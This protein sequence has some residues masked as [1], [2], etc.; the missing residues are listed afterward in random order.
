MTAIKLKT[1][2]YERIEH[3]TEEQF[4]KLNDIVEKEFNNTIPR[5]DKPKKRQLGTMPDLIKYMSPDFD[6]SLEDFKEYMPE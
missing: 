3:L 2:I 4:K 1:R 6:A 5:T